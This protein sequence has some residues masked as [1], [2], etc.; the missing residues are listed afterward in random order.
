MATIEAKMARKKRIADEG[1]NAIEQRKKDMGVSVMTR[2]TGTDV[3]QNVPRTPETALNSALEGQAREKIKTFQ[4]NEAIKNKLLSEEEQKIMSEQ[5]SAEIAQ[6]EIPKTEIDQQ[7]IIPQG[8]DASFLNIPQNSAGETTGI[9]SPQAQASA[10]TAGQ[11][12]V[13]SAG[14]IGT[15]LIGGTIAS[16][17]SQIAGLFRGADITARTA[18][19][20]K[21]A[22]SLKKAIAVASSVG[23]PILLRSMAGDAKGILGN[24]KAEVADTISALKEGA[25]DYPSALEK[26]K[27]A[28]GNVMSANND[29]NRLG[30][31]NVLNWL[32]IK[33]TLVD[34]EYALQKNGD[35]DLLEREL[36]R[37]EAMRR[38]GLQ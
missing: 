24:S 31:L 13:L 22:F 38:T 37:T 1:N 34:Y 15:G 25:I 27:K 33:D 32:G 35:F 29:L 12:G 16:A 28:K 23:A 6:T 7:P 11:A 18:T 8:A 5:K 9:N 20:A 30:S 26:F 3:S 2:P 36:L 21:T 10:E 17:S 19:T 4:Q 14:I